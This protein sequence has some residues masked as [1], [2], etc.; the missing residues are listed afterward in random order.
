MN[1]FDEKHSA[2]VMHIVLHVPA[3]VLCNKCGHIILSHVKSGAYTLY[4]C[5]TKI[6]GIY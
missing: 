5:K 4:H 3:K 2:I 1:V 6:V